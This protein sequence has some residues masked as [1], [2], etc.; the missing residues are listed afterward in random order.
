LPLPGTGL[1]SSILDTCCVAGRNRYRTTEVNNTGS[2]RR[3]TEDPVE[4]WHVLEVHPLDRANQSRSKQDRGPGRDLLDLI[5]LR[6]AGLGQLPHL[7]VL[8]LRGQRGP[9]L[10]TV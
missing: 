1:A 7:L 9:Q 5:V 3:V 8:G 2:A 4:V 6:V 10:R